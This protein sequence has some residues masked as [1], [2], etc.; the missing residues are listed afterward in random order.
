MIN[1][2]CPHCKKYY[3]VKG[4]CSDCKAE[5]IV[6]E[7]QHKEERLEGI[8]GWLLFFIF[9]LII[10]R[11][12]YTL[13]YLL[14]NPDFYY[15]GGILD[16]ATVLITLIFIIWAIVVGILLYKKHHSAVK[17]AKE[18]LLI[19]LATNL[20]FLGLSFW[21][22][23]EAELDL[24]LYDTFRGIVYFTIWFSYL[25]KSERVKNTYHDRKLNWKRAISLAAIV[26]IGM[27]III[28]GVAYITS[29]QDYFLSENPTE[30]IDLELAR[31]QILT[32]ALDPY[33]ARY[34]AFPSPDIAEDLEISFESAENDE[35]I[36]IYVVK[37]Q[38][39][40][41]N[42]LENKQIE[43]YSGC[44][45]EQLIKGN[46]S[47]VVSSG[48]VIIYNPNQSPIEYTLTMEFK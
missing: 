22:L 45:R 5:L 8:G 11:P 48:G 35:P 19:D 17:W 7:V 29:P 14:V 37:N 33:Y 31:I 43:V 41:D 13:Y 4:K 42:F 10:F 38:E 32:E 30:L 36:D 23:T 24:I 44:R 28:Y 18:F 1:Y 26:S 47:C 20:L 46:F 21:A 39:D 12:L 9:T 15:T 34:Y 2:Q 40:F 25:S 6:K 3:L 27:L 16:Y